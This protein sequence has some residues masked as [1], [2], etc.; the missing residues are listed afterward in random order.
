[1]LLSVP[2]YHL[3]NTSRC[4]SGPPTLRFSSSIAR[5]EMGTVATFQGNG[6]RRML[7][8]VI[9]DRIKLEE[10]LGDSAVKCL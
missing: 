4:I 8:E 6:Q 5:M 7:T 2:F 10:L 1:M 3:A 9:A